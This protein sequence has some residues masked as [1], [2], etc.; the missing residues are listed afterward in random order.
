MRRHAVPRDDEAEDEG[1]VADAQ[2]PG[3]VRG[4]RALRQQDA[5]EQ[6]HRRLARQHLACK[7]ITVTVVLQNVKA[8]QHHLRGDTA[9][10]V[11]CRG[12]NPAVANEHE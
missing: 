5:D 2:D 9:S 12:S 11:R 7:R 6:L 10:S 1:R 3:G 8:L 4:R